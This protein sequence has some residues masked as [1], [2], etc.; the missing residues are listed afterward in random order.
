MTSK[1]ICELLVAAG[2]KSNAVDTFGKTALHWVTERLSLLK[3]DILQR[4]RMYGGEEEQEEVKAKIIAELEAIIGAVS[5]PPDENQ[6]E[7]EEARLLQQLQ[8]IRIQADD[9]DL[10]QLDVLLQNLSLA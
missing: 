5:L 1:R 9:L 2:A 7:S 8:G 3:T 4:R 10:D 6:E